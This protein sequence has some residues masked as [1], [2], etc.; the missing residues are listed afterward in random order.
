MC[1]RHP[2][3]YPRATLAVCTVLLYGA[4]WQLSPTLSALPW[5]YQ[6][7]RVCAPNFSTDNPPQTLLEWTQHDFCYRRAHNR[8][9]AGELVGTLFRPRFPLRGAIEAAPN[10][11]YPYRNR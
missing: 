7:W 4:E 11:P 6:A 3:V 10:V 9:R 8:R 2:G 5:P 1:H